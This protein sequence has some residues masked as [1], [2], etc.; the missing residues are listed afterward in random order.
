MGS[1]FEGDWIP[2]KKPFRVALASGEVKRHLLKLGHRVETHPIV[3]P[4][5][6]TYETE[7]KKR[8]DK[9]NANIVIGFSGLI[10]PSKG[11]HTLIEAA[12][13]LKMERQVFTIKIAGKVFSQEYKDAISNYIVSRNLEEEIEWL[14][15]IEP[16]KL[17]EFYR[18]IDVI[19]FPS[20]YP[21]SFK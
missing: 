10:M 18:S 13:H 1:P 5:I 4:P 7:A 8:N 15:F 20:L 12:N 3:Y 21:E 19:A 2:S 16:S 9:E 6:T 17:G 14:D 11:L